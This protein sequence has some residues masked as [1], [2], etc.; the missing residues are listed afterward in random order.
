VGKWP[1]SVLPDPKKRL[2]SPV[3]LDDFTQG[4]VPPDGKPATVEA[5]YSDSASELTSSTDRKTKAIKK[6][7]VPRPRGALIPATCN[8]DIQRPRVNNVYVELSRMSHNDYTE[9]VSVLLRVFLELSTD[10]YI[11]IHNIIEDKA[12]LRRNATLAKKLKGVADDLRKHRKITQ[13][14]QE[15]VRRMA[16]NDRYIH[17]SIATFHQYVHSQHAAPIA[18]ELETIWDNT[19]QPFLEGVFAS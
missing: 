9:A 12:G 15:A 5:A 2:D 8:L 19:L 7:K 6:K 16:D 11:E 17:A 13:D 3:P 14:L 10:Y 1:P 4:R 18:S